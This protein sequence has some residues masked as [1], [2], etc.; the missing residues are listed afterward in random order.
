MDRKR[1]RKRL[2]IGKDVARHRRHCCLCRVCHDFGGR[3]S[4]ARRL[5]HATPNTRGSVSFHAPFHASH[6]SL[7]T[8]PLCRSTL[9]TYIEST[10]TSFVPRLLSRA[11]PVFCI[12]SCEELGARSSTRSSILYEAFTRDVAQLSHPTHVPSRFHVCPFLPISLS[13]RNS[14]RLSHLLCVNVALK[15]AV[16]VL[17]IQCQRGDTL[18][19]SAPEESLYHKRKPS[20]YHGTHSR[21]DGR[22]SPTKHNRGRNRAF[23][24]SGWR[25]ESLQND[26]RRNIFLS[27]A[28]DRH[29]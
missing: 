29:D 13:L 2:A 10:S 12:L 26:K 23:T 7:S 25:F 14:S 8:I 21:A 6:H 11:H 18:E 24:G 28:A 9:G 19:A 22:S 15:F 4:D 27:H 20:Q 3:L 5:C 16:S 17:E 1:K